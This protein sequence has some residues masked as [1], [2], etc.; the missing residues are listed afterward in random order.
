M[1]GRGKEETSLDAAQV[2]GRQDIRR[3][4]V[5]AVDAACEH[6]RGDGQA[7][8]DDGAG[9]IVRKWTLVLWPAR[10]G[11]HSR[12]TTADRTRRCIARIGTSKLRKN[13]SVAS[14]RSNKPIGFR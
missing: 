6:G 5:G 12:V 10:R 11:T 8:R 13:V 14:S 9:P 2:L 4:Y 7:H 3:G 1:G